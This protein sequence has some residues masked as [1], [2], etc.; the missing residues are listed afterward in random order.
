MNTAILKRD[1]IKFNVSST[2]KML[3]ENKAREYGMT[4]SELGRMLFGAFVSD[5]VMPQASK[6]LVSMA[7]KAKTQY[8]QGKGKGFKNIDKMLSYIDSL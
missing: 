2:F 4:I 1:F 7:E 6:Q 5:T 3:A 8:R